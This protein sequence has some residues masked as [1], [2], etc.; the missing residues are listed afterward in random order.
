MAPAALFAALTAAPAHSCCRTERMRRRRAAAAGASCQAAGTPLRASHGPEP[1]RP[2][3]SARLAAARNERVAAIAAPEKFDMMEIPYFEPEH[4]GTQVVD[5]T[6]LMST[7]KHRNI[8]GAWWALEAVLALQAAMGMQDSADTIAVAG[9]VALAWFLSDLGTGVF[10]WSV[11][12]YGGKS[13]PVFGT[14]IDA[15]QGHHKWPWTITKREFANNV[16]GICI[17][18]IPV[19]ALLVAAQTPAPVAAFVGA[20]LFFVPMSQQFHSWSHLR[21]TEVPPTV[22][23]LQDAG[24]LI[25]CKAHGAH[26]RPPFEGNY[27]IVSGLWNETLDGSGFFANMERAIYARTGVP[28]RSWDGMLPKGVKPFVKA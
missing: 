7:E 11:D 27:C 23:A 26:H 10:H 5:Q 18:I 8:V 1:A 12:N 6:E 25:S 2:R 15:F 3:T 19:Q 28:P 4:M 22:L 9:A 21:R 20:F 13:T 14:V 17:P 16:H 24:V